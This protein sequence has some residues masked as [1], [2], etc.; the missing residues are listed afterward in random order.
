[1]QQNECIFHV[2]KYEAATD[3]TQTT[4]VTEAPQTAPATEATQTELVTEASTK[5]VITACKN[6]FF[7]SK[8]FVNLESFPFSAL[9]R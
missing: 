9:Y 1:M 5:A 7:R 6:K 2:N 8:I 4:P 3:A